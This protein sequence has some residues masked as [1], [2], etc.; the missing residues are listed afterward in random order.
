MRSNLRPSAEVFFENRRFR[1]SN[2]RFFS[3][4]YFFLP[5]KEGGA[6]PILPAAWRWE[7]V[8]RGR[9]RLVTAQRFTKA[10]GCGM[11]FGMSYVIDPAPITALRV[12]GGGQFPVRRIFCIGK[13]YAAHV[14]EM[15][16]D[17]S[18]DPPVFFT[19]PADA[20]VQEAVV[21]FP[22]G[23]ED[24]HYE[25]ELVVALKA[26]GADLSLDAAGAAVFGYGAGCDL[27]RRDLQAIA[28]AAGSPWDTAK[29]FD[30]SAPLGEIVPLEQAGDLASAEL[31]TKINGAVRQNAPLS[32]MIWSIEQIIVGLSQ[33]YT[34][35]AGDLVFTGTPEG[36]GAVKR[37]DQVTIEIGSLPVLD[38][39]MGA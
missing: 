23:T 5:Q 12:A 18:K 33:L 9:V 21:P 34:L 14:A 26:G 8:S 20:A 30:N 2:G 22:P 19:K 35:K 38:F 36:V 16:G 7:G 25:G 28:R 39:K 37:G 29:G 6:A 15:G 11:G 3:S 13:N 17:A 10:H 24:L 4:P 1:R 27:T 32:Q 31:T